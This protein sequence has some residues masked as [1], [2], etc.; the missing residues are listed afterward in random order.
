MTAH[1]GRPVGF[2]VQSLDARVEDLDAVAHVRGEPRQRLAAVAAADDGEALGIHAAFA[3][4]PALAVAR[5]LHAD[6]V[7]PRHG[8]SA[9]V[10]LQGR[11][12]AAIG[13]TYGAKSADRRGV[14]PRLQPAVEIGLLAGTDQAGR[15]R[16][17]RLV[18]MF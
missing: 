7:W 13:V 14:A 17:A 5:Q 8:Q 16:G 3:P 11:G 18:A 6:V 1:V 4:A 9:G 15:M 10:D 12:L 2:A